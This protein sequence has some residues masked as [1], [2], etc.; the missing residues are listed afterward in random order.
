MIIDF[1]YF[2]NGRIWTTTVQAAAEFWRHAMMFKHAQSAGPA[3]V[4][5]D[6]SGLIGR[7]QRLLSSIFQR[8]SAENSARQAL[9]ELQQLDDHALRDIGLN[10]CDI[11]AYARGHRH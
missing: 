9:W 2:W 5:T 8:L 4:A 1:T 6:G 3:A 11:E 7:A 10:R